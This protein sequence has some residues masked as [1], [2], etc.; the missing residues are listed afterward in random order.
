MDELLLGALLGSA[1]PLV[2]ASLT[3]LAKAAKAYQEGKL[4][5]A[6]RR[7]AATTGPGVDVD[8][9]VAIR[10]TDY[11]H[12]S[13]QSLE[14]SRGGAGGFELEPGER[15]VIEITDKREPSSL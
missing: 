5:S 4:L 2:A 14:G 6:Q 13:E 12:G 9:K 10:V 8:A 15:L 11:S 7:K 3:T 1:V